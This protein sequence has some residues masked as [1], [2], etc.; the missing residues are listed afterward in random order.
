MTWARSTLSGLLALAVCGSFGCERSPLRDIV[1]GQRRE[2]TDQVDPKE[3]F[4]RHKSS[5][6]IACDLRW[7][8]E[9]PRFEVEVDWW[10]YPQD[11]K[12]RRKEH[13]ATLSTSR[14]SGNWF[15]YIDTTGGWQAGSYVCEFTSG[16]FK[17]SASVI[18]A[19]DD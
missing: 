7:V 14:P 4:N 13:H 12:S 3:R 11:G 9:G 19:D 17:K 1:S 10:F 18:A 5:R 8:K 6:D 2:Q 16:T 15:V